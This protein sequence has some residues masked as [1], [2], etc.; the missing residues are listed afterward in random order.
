MLFQIRQQN[1]EYL[2]N[3][4]VLFL[5]SGSTYVVEESLAYPPSSVQPLNLSRDKPSHSMSTSTTTN[6]RIERIFRHQNT[7]GNLNASRERD[8]QGDISSSAELLKKSPLRFFDFSVLATSSI[9]HRDVSTQ[10]S[11]LH[12]KFQM[13]ICGENYSFPFTD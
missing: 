12:I 4:H 13:S 10:T 8:K 6:L 3:A 9:T 5:D 7:N 1:H 2:I 11:A